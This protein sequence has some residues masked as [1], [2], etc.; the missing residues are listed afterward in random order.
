[1][2]KRN[3]LSDSNIA[4]EA[5]KA[6][7]LYGSYAKA[8]YRIKS[9]MAEI[10]GNN[11]MGKIISLGSSPDKTRRLIDYLEIMEDMERRQ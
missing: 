4:K 5:E 7:R 6:V 3:I 8:L 1:V 9:D 2:V 10:E 11:T